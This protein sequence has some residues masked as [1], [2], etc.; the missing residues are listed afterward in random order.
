MNILRRA[1]TIIDY[2]ISHESYDKWTYPKRRFV[3][4][5]IQLPDYEP[6]EGVIVEE[7]DFEL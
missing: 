2:T 7:N 5:Q 3:T 6:D 1:N 4:V